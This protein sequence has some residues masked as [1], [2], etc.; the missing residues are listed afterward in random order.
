[1]RKKALPERFLVEFG[2]YNNEPA[3]YTVRTWQDELKAVAVAAGHHATIHPRTP[4]LDVKVTPLG[5]APDQS[6]PGDDLADLVE[7]R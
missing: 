6:P 4:I 2:G 5:D 3:K 1:V 7:W